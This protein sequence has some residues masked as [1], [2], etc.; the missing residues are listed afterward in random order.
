[1][2]LCNKC[3]AACD[4]VPL[5]PDHRDLKNGCNKH[6]HVRR[7]RCGCHFRYNFATS[8]ADPASADVAADA[9]ADELAVHDSGDA[10]VTLL[11]SIRLP[12][13]PPRTLPI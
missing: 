3:W 12:L 7:R 6:V 4:N 2:V 11:L 8:V 13:T 1:M 10:S 5:Y 9:D